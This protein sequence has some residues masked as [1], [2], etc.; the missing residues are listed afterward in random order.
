MFKRI[1]H[2]FGWSREKETELSD[3]ISVEGEVTSKQKYDGTKRDWTRGQTLGLGARAPVPH[4]YHNVTLSNGDINFT[5]D[6]PSLYEEFNEGDRVLI[7]YKERHLV[8][9]DFVSPNFS[10]KQEIGRTLQQRVF[11]GAH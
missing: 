7:N 3:V 4:T 1:S 8:D 9:Y 6:D 2:K 11:I 10:K 5:V